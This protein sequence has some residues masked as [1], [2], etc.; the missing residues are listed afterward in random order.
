MQVQCQILSDNEKQVIHEKSIRILQ[1]V[2]VLFHS[3]KARQIL[4]MHG[5][6]VDE[7]TKIVC[8]PEELVKQALASA[9][10]SFTLGAR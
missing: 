5:A 7:E 8:I 6:K 1:E 2:G 9:P 3:R 10:R 4:K